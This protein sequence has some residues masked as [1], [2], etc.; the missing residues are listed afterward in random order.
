[1]I[2]ST[3]SDSACAPPPGRNCRPPPP[4]PLHL[5]VPA[6][7]ARC[8]L[9]CF[10]APCWAVLGGA[11]AWLVRPCCLLAQCGRRARRGRGS[12]ERTRRAEG[13]ASAPPRHS[14][15]T[16]RARKE[17]QES[18]C[19]YCSLLNNKTTTSQAATMMGVCVATRIRHTFF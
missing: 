3:D 8:L 4:P 19:A 11:A 18:Y 12:R 7:S 13:A 17:P 10:C 2:G 9:V 6:R 14:Q 15:P 16:S 5:L 1:M